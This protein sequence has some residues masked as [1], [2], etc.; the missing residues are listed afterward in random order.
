MMFF[1]AVEAKRNVFTL[2]AAT[3]GAANISSLHF[4]SPTVLSIFQVDREMI[5]IECHA[6]I[7]TLMSIVFPPQMPGYRIAE[8]FNLREEVVS[9]G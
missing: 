2:S 8:G 1:V 6:F 4:T 9:G 3:C 7:S 5:L